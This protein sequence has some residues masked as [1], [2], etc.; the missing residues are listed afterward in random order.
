MSA[1]KNKKYIYHFCAM[2]QE[3]E[4]LRYFDG[5]IDMED[6]IDNYEDYTEL[7]TVMIKENEGF[8]GK[9]CDDIIITS[10]SLL[11]KPI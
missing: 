2:V 4:N 8:K 10:L 5:I 3:S 7:K 11:R 1:S 6:S 9:E